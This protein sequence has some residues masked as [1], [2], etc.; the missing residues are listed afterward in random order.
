M[1]YENKKNGKVM[2]ILKQ[3]DKKGTMLIQFEDGTSTSITTGT[4]KRWYKKVEEPEVGD[5]T[6]VMRQKQELGI[7][8]PP[9]DHVEIVDAG[10]GTPLNEVGK[11][12][13][14]QAEQKATSS[15]KKAPKVPVDKEKAKS[16]VLDR[17]NKL[18]NAL[19]NLDGISYLIYDKLP[20]L[21]VI[22]QDK[23]SVFELRLTKF[24][25]TFNVRDN[26][27]DI[28]TDAGF[29]YNKVSNYYIPYAIKVPMEK[30]NRTFDT[31]LKEITHKEEK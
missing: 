8:C 1:R 16:L 21:I 23:K 5:V 27:L 24:G 4:F 18:V 22:K 26:L 19:D 28:L 20:N 15:K 9:I 2:T 29:E 30:L 25:A 3:D 11:E 14:E 6:E 31:L 10:D 12:I 13:A 17:R 7:E